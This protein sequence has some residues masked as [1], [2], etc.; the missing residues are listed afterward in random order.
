[1]KTIAISI[2]EPTLAAIDKIARSGGRFRPSGDSVTGAASRRHRVSRSELVRAA[3]QAFVDSERRAEREE[4][5]RRVYASQKER[6]NRQ[7]A[8]LVAEQAEP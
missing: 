5:D 8:A 2:D 3:L 6:I 1:M 7:A 4:R